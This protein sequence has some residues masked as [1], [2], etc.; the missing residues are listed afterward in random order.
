MN[1][2]IIEL[3]EVDNLGGGTSGNF[4]VD[5]KDKHIL[6]N[7]GD[8]ISIKSLFLDTTS[9]NTGDILIDSTNQNISVSNYLY[10][11]NFRTDAEGGRTVNFDDTNPGGSNESPNGN[12]YVV[13]NRHTTPPPP[14][15]VGLLKVKTIMCNFEGQLGQ[16]SDG[17][18]IRYQYLNEFN[19]VTLIDVAFPERDPDPTG[20]E[21][22]AKNGTWNGDII[23]FSKGN[24]PTFIAEDLKELTVQ[25][26]SPNFPTPSQRS[27]KGNRGKGLYNVGPIINTV[28]SAIV[29]DKLT[30]TTFTTDFQI[31]TGKYTPDLL[32]RTITDYLSDIIVYPPN[33]SPAE[34]I[35]KNFSRVTIPDKYGTGS[36]IFPSKSNFCASTKQLAYDNFYNFETPDNL[37]LVSSDGKSV[38][39]FECLITDNSYLVGSSELSLEYLPLIDKFQFTQLH[40]SQFSGSALPVVKYFAGSNNAFLSS[41]VG[42]IFFQS[43][44]PANLWFKTLGFDN[45]ICVLPEEA[46]LMVSGGGGALINILVPSFLTLSQGVNITSDFNGADVSIVKEGF[47]SSTTVAD[48]KGAD[49]VRDAL[50]IAAEQV[51]GTAVLNLSSIRATTSFSSTSRAEGYYLVQIEGLPRQDLTNLPNDHIQAIVSKYYASGSYTIMEGGAG[52]FN[53]K[54]IGTSFY[55]QN[56]R[57][58]ILEADGTDALQLGKNNTIFLEIFRQSIDY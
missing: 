13:C 54:H 6:L 4:A 35:N 30:P 56:L 26:P 11:T 28:E 3:R 27:S 50:S 45:S 25:P 17:F 15:Y 31:P 42:G 16:R 24:T 18:S 20:S 57:V 2:S 7:E 33:T 49:I 19:K 53:Y 51:D 32:A 1:S 29:G 8:E 12:I 23:F 10:L 39:D 46:K 55:L 22:I 38:M 21:P 14:G 34:R 36:I 9:Q 47:V 41:S 52:S 43:L 37:Y 58:K 5:L 44:S 40:T 48:Q